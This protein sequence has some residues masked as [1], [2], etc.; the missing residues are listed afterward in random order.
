MQHP[1]YGSGAPA[2]TPHQEV[3]GDDEIDLMKIFSVARRRWKLLLVGLMIGASI[4]FAYV[5][6]TTPVYTARVD[7]SLDTPE[8]ANTRSLSGIQESVVLD[9]GQITTEIEVIQSE[10]ISRKVVEEL[11]LTEN[12]L[13]F[14]NRETGT[15]RLISSLRSIAAPILNILRPQPEDDGLLPLSEED[16]AAERLSAAVGKLQTNMIVSR[17]RGS[18]ILQVS[19]TAM[20]PSLAARIANGIADVY[21]NDQ[22]EAKYDAN[23]RATNWLR[24]RAEQLRT[25]S[26]A[27]DSS[28]EEFKRKNGLIGISG[29]SNVGTEL[30]RVARQVSN[31]QADLLALEARVERLDDIV[32]RGDTTAAVSATATQSITSGLRSRFLETLKDYNSLVSRI[33]EDHEQTQRLAT[34]LEQ[35]QDLLFEEIKRSAEITAND[36]QVARERLENLEQS[37][38]ELEVQ[39]GADNE[40]LVELRELERNADT[41][42]SLYSNFLGRYQTSLQQ[43]SFP[44]SDVRVIN[45]AKSP[46]T[47]SDPRAARIL[48]LATILGFMVAAGYILIRELLDN[49]IR[50]EEQ[51]RSGLGMEF[52]GGLPLINPSRKRVL[53]IFKQSEDLG[54]RQISFSEMLKYAVNKPLSSFSE[55]LRSGKMAI[56]LRR[57][58][59][60]GSD[61]TKTAEGNVV[62]VV[63]CFPGEGKTTIATNM[64]TLLAKQGASVILIDADLRNPGLTRAITGDVSEGI[65]DVLTDDADWRDI[66]YEDEETGVHVLTSRLGRR[67]VHTSEIVGGPAMGLLIKDL[68]SHYDYVI[69]DLP[70]IGPVIDARAALQFLDGIFFVIKWGSTNVR[71]LQNIL[72]SDPRLQEKSYGAFLNMFDPKTAH[73]YG[74]Y[75]GS[76]YY[77]YGYTKYYADR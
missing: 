22:L 43:Q 7:I 69:M 20:S 36:V 42:R 73:Q 28:V 53:G 66:Y 71:F 55:T 67:V 74:S 64:A 23:E 59:K 48:A 10:A 26:N 11:N 16:I 51:I 61:H 1:N 31:A 49:K 37:R 58:D 8:A 70:P 72:Q 63:S 27:L 9:D 4:G 68:R 75:A 30:E 56:T 40:V 57:V 19:Y 35:L 6:T 32:A 15:S 12:E 54:H 24:D 17:V 21:I 45:P 65:I 18:R 33:G 62:G 39:L 14:A 38:D 5:A 52:L 60:H 47:P 25:Q 50:T 29:S 34:E 77:S 46:G 44:V 41:V 2:Y 13:F 76:H 3:A